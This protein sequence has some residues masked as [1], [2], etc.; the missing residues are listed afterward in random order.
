MSMAWLTSCEIPKLSH[1]VRA[2]CVQDT[3]A[4]VTAEG[5]AACLAIAGDI[6]DVQVGGK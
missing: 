1:F 2:I 3:S 4:L 5:C 6:G